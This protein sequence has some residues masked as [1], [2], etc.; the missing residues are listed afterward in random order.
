VADNTA[1]PSKGEMGNVFDSL[2]GSTP[3]SQVAAVSS[4]K[5]EKAPAGPPARSAI[6]SPALLGE[7][8]ATI[9]LKPRNQTDAATQVIVIN[10]VSDRFRRYLTGELDR[11]P[12]ETGLR[13]AGED[14][15]VRPV[16]KVRVALLS[17]VF[18]NHRQSPAE[19]EFR[20]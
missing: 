12:V 5:V 13:V 9:I 16:A 20:D 2:N 17:R 10:N 7:M 8:E 3:A 1:S 6:V 11:R 4:P 18:D 14:A 19:H 15:T